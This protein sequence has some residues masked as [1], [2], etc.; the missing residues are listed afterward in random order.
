MKVLRLLAFLL[1]PLTAL[2]CFQVEQTPTTLHNKDI[3]VRFMLN[4]K[5]IADAPVSLLTH[6]NR[7]V[8]RGSTD[9]NG[10]CVLKGI[11]D[12]EYR[13]ILNSP[14]YET[15]DVVLSRSGAEKTAMSV[16]FVGDWCQQV[17]IIQDKS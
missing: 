5:P 12:G 8:A 9:S 11:P 3:K 13:V 15:V 7:K 14:S 6:Q 1:T 10:W 17:S 2:A 16:S 4:G